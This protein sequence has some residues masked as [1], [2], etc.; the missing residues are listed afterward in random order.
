MYLSLINS[1]DINGWTISCFVNMQ[2]NLYA[3]IFSTF[4][5]NLNHSYI[6]S[7]VNY[8]SHPKV[9]KV[10]GIHHYHTLEELVR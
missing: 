1:S 6:D 2:T 9:S 3:N 4:L 10:E 8:E 5:D 7:K